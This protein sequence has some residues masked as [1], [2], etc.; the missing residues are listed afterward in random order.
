MKLANPKSPPIWVPDS[1]LGS[2]AQKNGFAQSPWDKSQGKK[3]DAWRSDSEIATPESSPKPV[4]KPELDA[5]A[6]LTPTDSTDGKAE[7]DGSTPGSQGVQADDLSGGQGQIGQNLADVDA[8]LS[9]SAAQI[10]QQVRVG[11]QQ[12]YVQGLKDGMAKTLLE[13]QAD[14]QAEK[15]LIQQVSQELVA[16]QQDAFR[17]F[18]PLRKLSLH[19]AEQ[20][21]RGELSLSG[22]AVE[23]LVKA[24]L[25]EITL[26][27]QAV[28]VHAHPQDL[29][30]VRPLLQA[31]GAPLKLVAD[32]H[33]LQ[34]SVRVRSNETVI[35]DLIQHRLESLAQKLIFESD[36]WIRNASNLA[37]LRVE[38]VEPASA[39]APMAMSKFEV[40]DVEDKTIHADT[41]Q[42]DPTI[43]GNPG[44]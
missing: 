24:C 11:R 17:L 21:V 37:G 22:L 35:E 14:R 13:L 19:I 25:A 44:P 31:S 10:E 5:A 18:E 40:E 12:G 1:L 36:D 41:D 32:P 8:V 30:K 42:P 26:D 43:Q 28:M 33:L 3:Q 34:G 15:D 6:P 2:R 39:E 27:D 9:V 23:R 38:T 7:T 29:E 16:L 20:L 4:L